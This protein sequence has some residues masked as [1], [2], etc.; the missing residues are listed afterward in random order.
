MQTC[1]PYSC[2][3]NGNLKKKNYLRWLLIN[4]STAK[5]STERLYGIDAILLHEPLK[6]ALS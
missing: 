1:L 6:H 5:F 2:S 4:F 3:K